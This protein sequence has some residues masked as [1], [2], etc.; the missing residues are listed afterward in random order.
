MK[1]TLRDAVRMQHMLR[2]ANAVTEPSIINRLRVWLMIL[3]GALA[4]ALWMN[5]EASHPGTIAH[6]PFISKNFCMAIWV[7]F[8]DLANAFAAGFREFINV[9]L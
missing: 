8:L 1:Y 7:R 2:E 4:I 6:L 9:W 3:S 5:M